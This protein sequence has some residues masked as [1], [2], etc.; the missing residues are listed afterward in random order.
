MIPKFQIVFLVLFLS[1]PILST[2]SDTRSV[3]AE[4][5][6]CETTIERSRR[7]L[8]RFEEVIQRLKRSMD[9]A[10]LDSTHTAVRDVFR[11]TNRIEYLRSRI[12]R[13]NGQRDKI[14]NDLR[15]VKG[16]SCPSC[17]SSSVNLYCRNGENLAGELDD[18][19]SEATALEDQLRSRKERTGSSS[20]KPESFS[21]RYRKIEKT[22]SEKKTL[23]ASCGSAAG[24]ALWEQSGINLARADSLNKAGEENQSL[25][26]LDL[27]ELLIQKA[28]KKCGEK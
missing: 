13:L 4:F 8:A 19:L 12:D 5:E 10:T 11:L 17:I 22:I 28:L 15:N 20:E 16:P 14:R 25:E 24:A 27:V 21:H 3:E 1:F 6:R 2:D 18:C 23:I 7:E 9:K 26:T